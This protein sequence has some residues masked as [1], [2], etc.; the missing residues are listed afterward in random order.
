MSSDLFIACDTFCAFAMLALVSPAK[1]FDPESI[2]GLATRIATANRAIADTL[3]ALDGEVN[4][5]RSEWRGEASEAYDNAHRQWSAQL[6]EMNRVLA[7]AALAADNSGKRYHSGRAKIE[8]LW[9]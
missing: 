2:Q 4:V 3:D 8:G 1:R 9:A 6:D 5:L 7:R